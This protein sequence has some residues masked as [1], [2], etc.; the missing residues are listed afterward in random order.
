[1]PHDACIFRKLSFF[2]SFIL[3][4]CYN[5]MENGSNWNHEWRRL[6]PFSYADCG[7][8]RWWKLLCHVRDAI[9][10][11][12]LL[13]LIRPDTEFYIF[14]CWFRWRHSCWSAAADATKFRPI[15]RAPL[16]LCTYVIQFQFGFD[17]L[18]LVMTG[19]L[20]EYGTWSPAAHVNA[21]RHLKV[22]GRTIVAQKWWI[23]RS[24]TCPQ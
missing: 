8:G 21:G 7:H 11:P 22:V 10:T 18:W 14:I 2:F 23:V 19:Q 12:S 1:M 17:F 20:I 16:Q 4:T 24:K 6:A 5:H 15:A 9:C 3:K 13:C